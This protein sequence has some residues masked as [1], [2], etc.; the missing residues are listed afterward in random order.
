MRAA[1]LHAPAPAHDAPLTIGDV[2]AGEY[3]LKIWHEKL[4][5]PKTK[6]VT[7]PATGTVAVEF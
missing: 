4:K 6:K 1:V 7:V 2:P 3:T 5:K